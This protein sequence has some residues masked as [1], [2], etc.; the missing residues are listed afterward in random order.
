MQF[1]TAEKYVT[2]E[3]QSIVGWVAHYLARMLIEARMTP[4]AVVDE[5]YFRMRRKKEDWHCETTC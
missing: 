4:E 5:I 3:Y 2:R 1:E